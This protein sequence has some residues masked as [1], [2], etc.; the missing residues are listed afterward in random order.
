MQ[1]GDVHG[2]TGQAD[3][4]KQ[5][6]HGVV[7]YRWHDDMVSGSCRERLGPEVLIADRVQDAVSYGQSLAVPRIH[8]ATSPHFPTKM[9]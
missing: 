6:C 2:P 9:L 8:L 7:R 4:V 1:R 3:L 5:G